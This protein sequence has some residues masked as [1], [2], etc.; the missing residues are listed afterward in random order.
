MAATASQRRSPGVHASGAAGVQSSGAAS[1]SLNMG[2][3]LMAASAGAGAGS[4]ASLASPRASPALPI[5]LG[6]PRS[7]G[8]SGG[9]PPGGVAAS[10]NSLLPTHISVFG[11]GVTGLDLRHAA[12]VGRPAV[13][14]PSHISEFGGDDAGACLGEW[15]AA[16]RGMGSGAPPSDGAPSPPPC[17]K[18]R[19]GLPRPATAPPHALTFS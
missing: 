15:E 5:K 12:A 14:L 2:A 17:Q 4:I 7:T 6:A 11:D 3:S 18:G 8:G 13:Q 9:G 16:R 10:P 1:G 19:P